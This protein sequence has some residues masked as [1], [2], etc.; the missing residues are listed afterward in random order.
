MTHATA[1]QQKDSIDDVAVKAKQQST[2]GAGDY[3]QVGA[4]LQIVGETLAEALDL[5]AGQ[6][7]LDVAAGNGNFSLAAARRATHVTSTD[8][9]RELL[10]KGRVRAVAEGFDI[11]FQV[12][13]AEALAFEDE[14]FDVVGSTFGVMFTPNQSQSAAEMLRVCR[15]GGKIGL[16]N[17]TPSSFI[18]QL[19]KTVGQY[20]PNPLP[21]PALWGTAEHLNTLFGASSRSID[22][23][24][25]HFNFKYSS[26]QG[27]LENF[28]LVYGP[29]RN[30]FLALDDAGQAGLQRDLVA[31]ID[32]FNVADDTTMVV[33][34]EYLEVVICK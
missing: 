13:D 11:D 21:S 16:A 1:T 22:I 3:A 4:T 14:Q 24:R 34:G 5:R 17:W 8:F 9:V 6:R 7:V 15:T 23:Q 31:L 33:P 2:W 27:W 26:P 20:I 29:V 19:F 28:K 18:G 32:T 25:R 12:A 10:E 30:A